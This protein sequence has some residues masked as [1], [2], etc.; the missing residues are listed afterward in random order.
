M[1]RLF[2]WFKFNLTFNVEN[3]SSGSYYYYGIKTDEKCLWHLQ[4]DR[5]NC[6]ALPTRDKRGLDQVLAQSSV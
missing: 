3:V 2:Y 6:R 4:Q 1:L 5:L